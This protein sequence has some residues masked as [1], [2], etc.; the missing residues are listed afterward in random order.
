MRRDRIVTGQKVTAEKRE[1]ARELR[2]SMTP[3]ERVL[4]QQL[5]ANRLDD[6]HFRR[7]QIIDGF[8]VDFYCH[9]AGLIIEVDGPIH[10]TQREAD[11]EREAILNGR[12]LT[13]LRFANRQVMNDM[14]GVLREIRGCLGVADPPPNPLPNW[15]GES[16]ACWRG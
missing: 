7:Q 11:A 3:A 9:E 10:D 16:G 4:W 14:N 1:M 12:G 2:R 5:R 13:I 8:I 6:R 15:E